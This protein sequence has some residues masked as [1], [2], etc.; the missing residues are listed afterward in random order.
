M[1]GTSVLF[2]FLVISLGLT[3]ALKNI[4]TPLVSNSQMPEATAL[5]QSRSRYIRTAILNYGEDEQ[6]SACFQENTQN[7]DSE[8]DSESILYSE[9]ATEDFCLRISDNNMVTF[10][11]VMSDG[12]EIELIQVGY[13]VSS[14][15][16]IYDFDLENV[17][18]SRGAKGDS[19]INYKPTSTNTISAIFL[20]AILTVED[21]YSLVEFD[22]EIETY[23]FETTWKAE[24]D[25]ILSVSGSVS[26]ASK[27]C[28]QA[29]FGILAD[30]DICVIYTSDGVPEVTVD[31]VLV[32]S[33]KEAYDQ[34]SLSFVYTNYD[35]TI[36]VASQS[37][38]SLFQVFSLMATW[39]LG[40]GKIIT[41]RAGTVTLN[42]DNEETD[43]GYAYDCVTFKT[44][45]VKGTSVLY[46]SIEAMCIECED[47]SCS[48]SFLI[49]K[50]KSEPVY[51]SFEIE[52]DSDVRSE[53]FQAVL[54]MNQDEFTF[55][56]ITK[57]DEYSEDTEPEK[58]TYSFRKFADEIISWSQNANDLEYGSMIGSLS[59]DY[60]AIESYTDVTN[61]F[62]SVYSIQGDVVS[63]SYGVY[64]SETHCMLGEFVSSD[65]GAYINVVK[66]YRGFFD[67]VLAYRINTESIIQF[68]LSFTNNELDIQLND[69]STSE[70][71]LFYQEYVLQY[72][73][74]KHSIGG[75]E[76]DEDEEDLNFNSGRAYSQ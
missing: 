72:P 47:G 69:C 13:F 76:T 58:T 61:S 48:V 66:S 52:V 71:W 44:N 74:R 65:S 20:T 35:E 29:D 23:A 19:S 54:F 10:N 22:E 70:Q 42:I 30:V 45:I 21:D 31:G 32:F 49:K 33:S 38:Q 46:P 50:E 3:S 1:K 34:E 25:T 41:K 39:L 36:T 16:V 24:S 14:Y 68:C 2:F 26:L 27:E 67:K 6:D 40:E 56:L 12:E 4:Q 75:D 55:R 51:T 15:R 43:D 62:N 59:D 53:E 60:T 57:N 28:I 17:Y 64:C 8:T 5:V 73:L 9:Y 37:G 7:S 18:V 11:A 63:Q